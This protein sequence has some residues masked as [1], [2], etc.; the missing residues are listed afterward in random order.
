MNTKT[1]RVSAY[2]RERMRMELSLR[3][4]ETIAKFKSKE[5]P[6]VKPNSKDIIKVLSNVLTKKIERF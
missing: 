3:V 4:I 1:K 2:R 6:G 5:E